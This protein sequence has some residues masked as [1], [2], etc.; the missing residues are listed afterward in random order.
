[1]GYVHARITLIFCL[2]IVTFS[3]SATSALMLRAEK[4]LSIESIEK[5]LPKS[6]I[7]EREFKRAQYALA[8]GLFTE[9][10]TSIE[11][12]KI[13]VKKFNLNTPANLHVLQRNCAIGRMS[14]LNDEITNAYHDYDIPGVIKHVQEALSIA[15]EEN[16]LIP[17][18]ILRVTRKILAGYLEPVYR[19]RKKVNIDITV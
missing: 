2:F 17:E 14:E 13:L 1:M 4:K 16:I 10:R 11:R 19:Q 15:D 9:A 12:I 3:T 6:Q 7:I 8:V 5:T 18:Q